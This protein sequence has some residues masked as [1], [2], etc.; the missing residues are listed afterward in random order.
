V[1]AGYILRYLP[2]SVAPGRR[3]QYL[4][5]VVLLLSLGTAG[6][7]SAKLVLLGA[8]ECYD[9]SDS[10]KSQQLLVAAVVAL[11]AA[12]VPSAR[13]ETD[14]RQGSRDLNREKHVRYT[15]GETDR[16]KK[17][18]PSLNGSTTRAKWISCS[19]IVEIANSSP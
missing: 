17:E 9:A 14:G 10:L 16:L 18:L 8:V 6:N 4:V 1:V 3:V 5:E 7:W 11:T 15:L 13:A 2:T 12:V 19:A